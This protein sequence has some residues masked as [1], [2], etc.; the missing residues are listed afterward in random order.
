[1]VSKIDVDAIDKLVEMPFGAERNLALRDLLDD[2][3]EY[4]GHQVTQG[5]SVLVSSLDEAP[6]EALQE[7]FMLHYTERANEFYQANG[8]WVF[9]SRPSETASL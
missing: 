8:Q 4:V 1:M 7:F 5:G 6:I 9:I 3:Y 2:D